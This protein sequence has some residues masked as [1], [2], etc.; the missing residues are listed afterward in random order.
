[1][2][3]SSREDNYDIKLIRTQKGGQKL[4]V[5][6]YQ[7]TR[8]TDNCPLKTERT[9]IRWRCVERT[10]RCHGTAMTDTECRHCS[11]VIEHNHAN[12]QAAAECAVMVDSM[13]MRTECSRDKPGV[14]VTEGIQGLPDMARAAL[15]SSSTIKRTLRNRRS[16]HH[17]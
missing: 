7:Y 14:I 3:V 11:F 16:A 17:P 9:T 10:A 5:G 2:Y 12:D 8:Q 4:R 13:K 15:P 1:M 6:G